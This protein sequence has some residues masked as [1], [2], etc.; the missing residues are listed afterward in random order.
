M[1]S[2]MPLNVLI[3]EDEALL[4]MDL[5]SIVEDVGHRVVASAVC[6]REVQDLPDSIEPS[7]AFVD[8]HLAEGSTG[9]EVSAHIKAH[10]PD[11]IIV[12]VTAN[13]RKIPEGFAGAHGVVAKPFSRAGMI[14]AMRYLEEGILDPPPV[15]P[16]PSSFH[17]SPAFA[18][19]WAEH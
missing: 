10:W 3:V 4:A 18:A 6:L 15:S 7:L 8:M 11:A 14:T 17:A 2:H 12:F 19:T 16:E 13:V 1:T 5:E 9:L